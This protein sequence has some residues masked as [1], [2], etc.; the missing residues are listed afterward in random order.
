MRLKKQ[1]EGRATGDLVLLRTMP[2]NLRAS[3]VA[4]AIN[5]ASSG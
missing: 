4:S 5:G 3:M 2:Y 1:S